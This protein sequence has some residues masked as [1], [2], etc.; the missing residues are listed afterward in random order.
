MS[1][2]HSTHVVSYKF[3]IIIWL[4][5]LIF[6]LITIEIAQFDLLALTV[7]VA[8]IV[9]S[10]KTFLVGSYFMHLKFENRFLQLIVVGVALLFV[11]V[12]IVLFSDYLF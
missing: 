4:D 11:A 12:L 8:L 2:E 10:L 3:N 7:I 6:T 1:E 5:L 9:A